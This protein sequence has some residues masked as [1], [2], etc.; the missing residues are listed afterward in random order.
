MQ[1]DSIFRIQ[2]NENYFI[3]DPK[4]IEEVMIIFS[5]ALY[6]GLRGRPLLSGLEHKVLSEDLRCELEKEFHGNGVVNNSKT[7]AT[8]ICLM[9]NKK[10][11]VKITD[12]RLVSLTSS[13]YK[14]I[15]RYLSLRLARSQVLWFP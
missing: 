14:I 7:N 8:W 6:K 11:P 3:E 12:F 2:K 13:L 1:I 9:P 4:C 5:S 10:E 15:A